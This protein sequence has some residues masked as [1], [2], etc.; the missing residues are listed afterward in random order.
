[1]HEQKARKSQ[2]RSDLYDKSH[3]VERGYLNLI[4]QGFELAREFYYTQSIDE[5][6]A[7][8]SKFM[9]RPSARCELRTV[10]HWYRAVPPLLLPF[11][12][13]V[14]QVTVDNLPQR[15]SFL[16]LINL[17]SVTP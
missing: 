2:S 7:D 12:C 15:V 5:V 1:M 8:W 17:K 14:C 9:L 3:L 16:E 4:R 11:Q 10:L 6:E 13:Q